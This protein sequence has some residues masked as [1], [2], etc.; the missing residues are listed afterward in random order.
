MERDVVCL[1]DGNKHLYDRGAYLWTLRPSIVNRIRRDYPKARNQDFI[2][3][4]H[5]LPYQVEMIQSMMRSDEKQ[6]DKLNR[7]LTRTMEDQEYRVTDVNETL[8][9]TQTFGQKIADR[10]AEIAG[11]WGFIIFYII[12][13]VGWIVI[14]GLHVFGITFDPYPFI[15]LNLFLSCIAA[16]QAPVIMMSQNRAA[17][18]DRMS[19]ENDYHI[20]L[21]T[22]EELRI[23]HAKMDHLMQHQFDHNLEIQA[24]I[25]EILSEIRITQKK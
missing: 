10:V 5:L 6:I 19:S 15:L 25:F 9:E 2:C 8:K 12:V 1:V 18:R 21:K 23:L 24:M 16:L 20:N 13:L 14:N 17:Y 4:E 7:K 11:S 3:F 22:E